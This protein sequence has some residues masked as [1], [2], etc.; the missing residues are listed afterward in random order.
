MPKCNMM[1]VIL[2]SLYYQHTRLRNLFFLKRY[3]NQGLLSNYIAIKPFGNYF[4]YGKIIEVSFYLS[5]FAN[6]KFHAIIWDLIKSHIFC[7]LNC[8][9]KVEHNVDLFKPKGCL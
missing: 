6:Q 1:K 8:L 2:H 7:P 4:V 9:N 3:T 5:T